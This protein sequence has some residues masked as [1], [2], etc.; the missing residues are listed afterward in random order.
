MAE[1]SDKLV[2]GQ[3]KLPCPL[4]HNGFD[5]PKLLPC[6][7]TFCRNCLTDAVE[8]ARLK[9]PTCRLNV[10]RS[11]AGIEGLLTNIF[12]HNILDVLVPSQKSIK[13][14][15]LDLSRDSTLQQRWRGINRNEFL[16]DNRLRS[17]QGV[18][19][20]KDHRIIPS[21]KRLL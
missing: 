1:G 20:R 7:H 8:N 14:K 12:S 5:N 18:R 11:E 9:C 6:L 17:H 13:N 2:S 19:L 3:Y 16:C 21:S 15:Q 4:C 10:L